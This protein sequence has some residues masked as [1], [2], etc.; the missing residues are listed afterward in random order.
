MSR[1][2][3]LRNHYTRGD[4][5]VT[6]LIDQII[7]YRKA[8]C[9][10]SGEYNPIEIG[11]LSQTVHI[12]KSL[13]HPVEIELLRNIYS[14]GFYLVGVTSSTDSRK[15]YLSSIMNIMDEEHIKELIKRDDFEE[16]EQTY[17][18]NT[19]AVYQQSDIFIDIDKSLFTIASEL[20]RFVSLIF[21]TPKESTTQEEH[22]MFMAHAAALRSADL[23]R[24]V[25]AV[26]VSKEGDILS[27]GANDVPKFG[28]GQY[29]PGEDDMRDINR[30]EGDANEEK[31]N[32]IIVKVM[33]KFEDEWKRLSSEQ[34]PQNQIPWPWADKSE[35]ELAKEGKSF[36]KGSGISD[37]TE[38]G[39]A[40]HA[41]MEALMS[42]TRNGIP[43]RGATLFTTTY[44]C[45]NCAKHIVAAGIKRVVYIEP[46]PKSY[47][48]LSHGDAI[49]TDASLDASEVQRK[50]IFQPFSGIGP[51]RY[52][53]MF[54]MNLSQGRLIERKKE[55]SNWDPDSATV[56]VPLQPVS[57]LEQEVIFLAPLIDKVRQSY[58]SKP[59]DEEANDDNN[60]QEGPERG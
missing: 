37:L 15:E 55:L 4:A 21:G 17:G 51:R 32:D 11:P 60:S 50:V 6:K 8:E 31:K 52:L 26:I 1:G 45:H 42:C 25:G 19:R 29:W 35:A 33:K 7:E 34:A 56:R 9:E 36:L 12:I 57:Y 22:A 47:A 2:N 49:T 39:R 23:S 41:E 40:V 24:Q 30:E 58:T 27:T 3:E 16:T 10:K 14:V 13:K 20:K 5:V 53:D 59:P 43:V 38:Y 44:P 46:Y 18:Q 48:T 28:G 54:S